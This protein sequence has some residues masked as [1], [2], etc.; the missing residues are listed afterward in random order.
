MMLPR[1]TSIRSATTPN[2]GLTNSVGTKFR[3]ATSPT[4]PGEPV[5]TQAS[6]PMMTR[7]AQNPFRAMCRLKM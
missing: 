7:C 6:H 2:S 3:K 4:K 5:S 1:R